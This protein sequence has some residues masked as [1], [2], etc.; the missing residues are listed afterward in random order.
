MPL[1]RSLQTHGQRILAIFVVNG[2]SI[3]IIFSI[4]YNE[5]HPFRF[6]DLG[7]SCSPISKIDFKVP[8][9]FH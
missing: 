7:I 4:A 8:S 2:G 6:G 1:H 5:E 3:L 9:K